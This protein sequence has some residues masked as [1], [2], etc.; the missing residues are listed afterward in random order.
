MNNVMFWL[1]VDVALVIDRRD[2]L[3]PRLN[4]VNCVVS[5]TASSSVDVF[6]CCIIYTII[7]LPD[8]SWLCDNIHALE[9]LVNYEGVSHWISCVFQISYLSGWSK[10]RRNRSLLL[11]SCDW[12]RRVPQ[13]SLTCNIQAIGKYLR[14]FICHCWCWIDKV[15]IGLKTQR[16]CDLFSGSA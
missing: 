11:Y 3:L 8:W 7:Q 16:G 9:N 14:L 5:S 6:D 10:K 2:F 1:R 13:T 15:G 4:S 12:V